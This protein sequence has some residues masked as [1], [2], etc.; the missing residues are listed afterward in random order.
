MRAV[1]RKEMRQYFRSPVGYVF[2]AIF[3]FINAGISRI[4]FRPW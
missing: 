4:I 1:Y 2:L 3:L